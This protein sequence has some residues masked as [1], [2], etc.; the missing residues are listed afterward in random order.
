MGFYLRFACFFW[1]ALTTY[2][3]FAQKAKHIGINV[4]LETSAEVFIPSYGINYEQRFT[5]RSGLEADILYRNYS[6]SNGVTFSGDAYGYN[7]AV[8]QLKES[9]ISIPA[10]Y[11]F[12]TRVVDV[13]AGPSFEF[14]L[15]W[16]QK[17]S[18]PTINLIG[19]GGIKPFNIGLLTKV[20]KNVK[21][22]EKFYL[23]PEMR[24]NPIITNDRRYI[25][26]G[27]AGKYKL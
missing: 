26:I 1:L 4:I 12:Y 19:H 2:A 11:K 6:Q 17:S 24:I 14:Y 9:H 8:I 22:T 27:I 13:A 18:N 3:S 7:S 10:L 23:E 21:L 15:G 16:T 25:G 5:K 20:S